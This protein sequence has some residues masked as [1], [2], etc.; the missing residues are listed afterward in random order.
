MTELYLR[1]THR[2]IGI[3]LAL[4]IILQAASGTL[5]VLLD[6][7]PAPARGTALF[8]IKEALEFLHFGGGL[9]GKIYRLLLGAGLTGMA[10][11]G[12]LIFL[13]IRARTRKT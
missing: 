6:W 7:L 13:K 1:T 11:S 5:I 12:I 2:T 8:E 3:T 10:A 4:F 9:I